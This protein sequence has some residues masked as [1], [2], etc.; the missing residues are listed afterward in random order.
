MHLLVIALGFPSPQN[1]YPSSFIGQQVRLLC[2][3]IEYITVL[4]PT[5]FVPAFMRRFH[6]VA[7]RG[8]IARP[9]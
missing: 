8:I 1:P 9:L 6:R 3:R 2:E 7:N 5:T 4:S